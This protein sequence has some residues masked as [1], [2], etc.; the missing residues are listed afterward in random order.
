MTDLD[1]DLVV[2]GATGFVGRLVA[3]HLARNAPEGTRVGLAGRSKEKLEAV[4]D[5]LDRDWPLLVVDAHDPAE[6]VDSARVVCTT[7]GPYVRYGWPL[8]EA[9]ARSGTH[10]LDLTGEVLFVRR[11]I[12]EL[13]EAAVASGA[14]VVPSCGFDSIPSDLAV[15]LL[16]QCAHADGAGDLTETRL[17]ASLK[18]GV[19]GGTVDSLRSQVEQLAREPE[20]ARLVE[21]P[22]ALSPDRA[23]EPVLGDERDSRDVGRDAQGRWLGPFVMAQYNTR[24]VRRSNAL[25]DWSYG[26]TFRYQERMSFGRSVFG[27]VLAA[28]AA[29]TMGLGPKALGFNPTRKAL[30]ALLPS[31]G[32][33]PSEKARRNGWFRMDVD[34]VTTTGA[35][36]HAVVAAQGDPGYA[37]TAVMMGE[38]ALALA[39]DDLPA[40]AGVLTPA[41]AM[42][43]ALVERLRAQGAELSVVTG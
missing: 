33:G 17:V 18:G 19:S 37:A 27:P 24:V 43:D 36:Y 20:K 8:V 1:L 25:T 7:V 42:G 21:D 4:R 15:H 26:R 30:D 22:Y 16:A 31:P 28:G 12:D 38:S 2:F 34:T 40:R 14:K 23:A 5:G 6:L 3:E 13:H 11:V 35:C 29:A 39:L 41:T 32:E 9:C 10:Y